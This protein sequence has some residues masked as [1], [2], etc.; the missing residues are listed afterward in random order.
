MLGD[1]LLVAP[2]MEEGKRDVEVYFPGGDKYFRLDYHETPAYSGNAVVS[3]GE[4][5][6]IPGEFQKP[7]FRLTLPMTFSFPESR[8]NIR[9]ERTNQEIIHANGKRPD[10]TEHCAG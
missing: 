9:V 5:E 3:A 7:V 2:V 10:Y 4:D 8:T 1:T 6:Q